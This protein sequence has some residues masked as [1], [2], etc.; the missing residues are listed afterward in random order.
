MT[1][2]F[3]SQPFG[4]SFWDRSNTVGQFFGAKRKG[5]NS[6]DLGHSLLVLIF[7]IGQIQWVNFSGQCVCRLGQNSND[8]GHTLGSMWVKF[9]GSNQKSCIISVT[10]LGRSLRA[11]IKYM[12]KI[13]WVTFYYSQHLGH[14][15]WLLFCG[16]KCLGHNLW[17]T[18][19]RSQSVS[20]TSFIVEKLLTE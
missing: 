12:S 11:T 2:I 16:S 13:P 8:L 10:V 1:K 3:G 7:G 19:H 14:L 5:Q 9:Y 17:G 4:K 6:N 20:L 15:F 18:F